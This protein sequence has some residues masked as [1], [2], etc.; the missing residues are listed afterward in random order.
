M[1]AVE[2]EQLY[3]AYPALTAGSGAPAH[4]LKG[5][6][7]T[8]ERGEFLALM[9]ATG[10]GKTTLCLAMNGIVP[11]ST[12]GSIRGRVTVLGL[13]ARATPVAQLATRVGIVFQ[14][15]ESQL[16]SATVEEEV[17]FG[18][19][20][21]A[22]PPNEMAA[23]V[24]W[25]LHVVGMSA[26]RQRSP[27]HLSGG[28]KQRVAIAASLAMQPELLILDEPTAGLDPLGQSEVFAAIESL[29]RERQVT[30]V[31]VSQD[32]DRVAQ[33]AQ[34]V[35][36]LSDGR[37]ARVDEPLVVF[38]DAALMERAGIAP[39]QVTELALSLNRR[40]GTNLHVVSLEDAAARL[41]ESLAGGAPCR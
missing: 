35:A 28:Q 1:A 2:I 3:Y 15:P 39:P 37:I 31:M 33:F 20:N 6:E 41:G 10:A 25:A 22:V 5:V 17:A 12:G 8:V 19:G 38:E 40:H 34:R 7:L 4:I 36:V 26:E 30:I 18:L 23:R 13:D 11:Q 24:D 27:A 29:R 21:L 32:A 14:D 9:G 16:F